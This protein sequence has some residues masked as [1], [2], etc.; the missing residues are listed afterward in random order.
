MEAIHVGRAQVTWSQNLG[1]SLGSPSVSQASPNP[2]L[3]ALQIGT[4]L[5]NIWNGLHSQ[6]ALTSFNGHR[7]SIDSL[8]IWGNPVT[9]VTRGLGTR[10]SPEVRQEEDSS[11]GP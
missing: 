6:D 1:T 3:D 10:S 5:T 7:Q 11:C 2:F 4:L 9:P 8:L